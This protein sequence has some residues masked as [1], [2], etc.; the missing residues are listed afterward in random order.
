MRQ[1]WGL[2]VCSS[3]GA[4]IDSV[5]LWSLG[6]GGVSG[7]AGS[8][9]FRMA[10]QEVGLRVWLHSW[11][12]R[13]LEAGGSNYLQIDKRGAIS[14]ELGHRDLQKREVTVSE[15]GGKCEA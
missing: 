8:C 9:Q 10:V 1:W 4:G 12:I 13:R 6:R 2:V 11:S 15:V 5:W 7:A 14:T 3:A